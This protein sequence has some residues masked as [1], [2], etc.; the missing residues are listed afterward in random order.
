MLNPDYKDILAAFCDHDVQF[1]LIGAYA[2]AAGEKIPQEGTLHEN[3]R[4][5]GRALTSTTRLEILTN[6]L[7]NYGRV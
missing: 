6:L 1:L 5:V 7:A 2:L 4:Q 3:S